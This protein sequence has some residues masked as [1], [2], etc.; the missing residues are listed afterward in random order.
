MMHSMMLNEGQGLLV[1]SSASVRRIL[2]AKLVYRRM[3]NE[4][5]GHHVSL[6]VRDMLAPS[7]L[8]HEIAVMVGR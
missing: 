5:L 2:H 8:V 1:S 7:W 6:R 3:I 4:L